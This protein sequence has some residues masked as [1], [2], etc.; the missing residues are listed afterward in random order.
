MLDSAIQLLEA[1]VAMESLEDVDVD[2]DM[3]IEIPE[4]GLTHKGDDGEEYIE[5]F[6]NTMIIA[7]DKI[8]KALSASEDGQKALKNLAI[9]TSKGSISIGRILTASEQELEDAGVTAKMMSTI[10][11]NLYKMSKSNDY[12]DEAGNIQ[13]IVDVLKGLDWGDLSLSVNSGAYAIT[14]N[15]SGIY[16]FNWG[17]VNY[18]ALAQEFSNEYTKKDDERTKQIQADL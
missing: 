8:Y 4:I 6:E 9:N 13:S 10:M 15:D 12:K 18:D 2:H 3:E 5:Q 7:R 1:I 11:T 16:E 14:I 17:E